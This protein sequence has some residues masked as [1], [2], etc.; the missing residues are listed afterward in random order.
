M[1]SPGF[2]S[3]FVAPK[4]VAEQAESIGPAVSR[5]AAGDF[6]KSVSRGI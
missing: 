1:S 3:T 2:V 4:C 5:A 6:S